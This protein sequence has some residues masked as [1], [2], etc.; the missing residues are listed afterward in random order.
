MIY[1]GRLVGLW[2]LQEAICENRKPISDRRITAHTFEMPNSVLE[3]VPHISPHNCYENP[4]ISIYVQHQLMFGIDKHL[5]H[6]GQIGLHLNMLLM[7]TTAH[8]ETIPLQISEN[9]NFE[10]NFIVL[11]LGSG[12]R[13]LLV[14]PLNCKRYLQ[15]KVINSSS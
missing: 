14:S 6:D 2:E 11:L 4:I 1:V 5:L 13:N 12:W 3:S 15:K 7:A 10:H 9:K 8:T